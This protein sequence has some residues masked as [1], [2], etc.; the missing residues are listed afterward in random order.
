MLIGMRSERML[1]GK[2]KMGEQ[3]MEIG[4]FAILSKKASAC[5]TPTMIWM[6][7]TN[8]DHVPGLSVFQLGGGPKNGSLDGT[9]GPSWGLTWNEVFLDRLWSGSLL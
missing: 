7:N 3:T 1:I 5:K 2:S 4:N 8:T 9:K 6:S